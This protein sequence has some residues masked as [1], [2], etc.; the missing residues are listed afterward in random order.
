[1]IA[2]PFALVPPAAQG[3]ACDL[4]QIVNKQFESIMLF[5]LKRQGV[6]VAERER[7]QW[8]N[9]TKN[10]SASQGISL[11]VQTN[12]IEMPQRENER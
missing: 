2:G 1:M 3:V 4:Q 9:M 5:A 10:R 11:K 7:V 6:G 8:G 12:L